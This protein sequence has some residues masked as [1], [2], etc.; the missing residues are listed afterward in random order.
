MTTENLAALGTLPNAPLV[1]V[2]AQVRFLPSMQYNLDAMRE[3]VCRSL[4]IEFPNVSPVYAF[5][6]QLGG[7]VFGQNLPPAQQTLMGFEL[8]SADQRSV[9]RLSPDS[10]TLA[11]SAYTNFEDFMGIWYKALAPLKDTGVAHVQ[12]VGLRYVDF[13]YPSAGRVPEDYFVAPFDYRGF[14]PVTGATEVAQ[15]NAHI[16]EYL[17]E[18]G[19]MRV[20]YSRGIGQP[21]L[22]IELQGLL[23]VTSIHARRV[24]QG[25]TAIFDTDRWIDGQRPSDLASLR[26]DFDLLHTGVS[27][28][29][30]QFATQK[31]IDEWSTPRDAAA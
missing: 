19:R 28:A 1:L 26:K 5:N 24:V 6:V 15:T 27:D 21:A 31:A 25:A 20:Q 3:H 2:L 29:F 17:L 4:A 11:V 18:Q 9:I 8:R 13:I 22:P 14:A 16:Q 10:I 12:R 23:E 7:G 30:K